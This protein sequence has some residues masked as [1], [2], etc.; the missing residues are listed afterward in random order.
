MHYRAGKN[1]SVRSVVW[2]R[3]RGMTHPSVYGDHRSC[4]ETWVAL[5]ALR[6]RRRGTRSRAVAGLALMHSRTAEERYQAFSAE[7]RLGLACV[8][9]VQGARTSPNPFTNATWQIDASTLLSAKCGMRV[10]A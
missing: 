9:I 4:L 7:P 8:H 2:T 6:L 3:L 10:H 5:A 1:L